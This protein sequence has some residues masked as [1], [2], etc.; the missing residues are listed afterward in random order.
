MILQCPIAAAALLLSCRNYSMDMAGSKR[1]GLLVCL[2]VFSCL[3][4]CVEI[5]IYLTRVV[6]AAFDFLIH[7]YTLTCTIVANFPCLIVS[8]AES[9]AVCMLIEWY[10]YMNKIRS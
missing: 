7:L 2:F 1:C 10:L 5:P 3:P 4:Q 6:A 8:C 9:E